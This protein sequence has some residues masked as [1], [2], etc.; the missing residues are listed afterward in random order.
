MRDLGD[1]RWFLGI[2]I[3]RDRDRRRIWLSQDSHIENIVARF[4]LDQLHR[5]PLTP[6]ISEPLIPNDEV[7]DQ[8]FI[9]LYQRKVV[10]HIRCG[11][12]SSGCGTYSRGTI[13]LFD[14]SVKRPY[15]RS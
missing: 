12:H 6:M 9:P 10:H 8:A 2:R 4:N 14:Q 13:H 5:S 3:V 7:A 15:G 11:H 1:L